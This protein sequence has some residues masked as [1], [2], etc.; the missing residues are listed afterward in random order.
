MLVRDEQ[1]LMCECCFNTI[2]NKHADWKT[3]P[4]CGA[5]KYRLFACDT[6]MVEIVR[7]LNKKGYKTIMCC[8]G[9]PDMQTFKNHVDCRIQLQFY[10]KYDFDWGG[11]WRQVCG[12]WSLDWYKRIDTP[13][14]KAR[15]SD[16]EWLSELTNWQHETINRITEGVKEL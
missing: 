14:R 7:L 11:E 13:T 12:I 6:N 5:D 3:C 8:G 2:E 10:Q 9:H 4:Y 1:T 16:S 15:N